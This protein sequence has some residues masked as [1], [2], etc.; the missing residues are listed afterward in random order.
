M[1]NYR[2]FFQL[3]FDIIFQITT[4]P[5]GFGSKIKSS[6]YHLLNND[7]VL[8][9]CCLIGVDVATSWSTGWTNSDEKS[10]W[11]SMILNNCWYS[12]SEWKSMFFDWTKRSIRALYVFIDS[13]DILLQLI[14]GKYFN[15][16]L[17]RSSFDFFSSNSIYT[18]ISIEIIEWR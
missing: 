4:D 14:N 12:K 2:T 1:I 11:I 6:I 3:S 5:L 10:G 13:F 15:K 7:W 16:S 17:T 18:E 9:S 8:W